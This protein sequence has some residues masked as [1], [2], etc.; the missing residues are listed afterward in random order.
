MA[1]V[2][3]F[4]SMSDI[5]PWQ[6]GQ[7]TTKFTSSSIWSIVAVVLHVY[8]YGHLSTLPLDGVTIYHNS[9]FLVQIHGI[10]TCLVTVVRNRNSCSEFTMSACPPKLFSTFGKA[11]YNLVWDDSQSRFLRALNTLR[12]SVPDP[13][14]SA[15]SDGHLSDGIL[16][17]SNLLSP[18][19]YHM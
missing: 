3:Y 19:S 5:L 14:D 16:S 2:L 12:S 6:S 15:F 8:H 10:E 11:C 9:R 4:L 13:S 1:M 7:K 18:Y 17:A